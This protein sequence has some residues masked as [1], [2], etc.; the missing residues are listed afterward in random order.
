MVEFRDHVGNEDMYKCGVDRAA[1][2]A[3]KYV[4]KLA[5]SAMS[6]VRFEGHPSP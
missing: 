2:L 1:G 5:A 6:G 3:V 4:A